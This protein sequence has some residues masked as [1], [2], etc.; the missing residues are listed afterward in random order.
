MKA[1]WIVIAA[2]AFVVTACGKPPEQKA[3]DKQWAAFHDVCEK[4]VAFAVL[5]HAQSQLG[6]LTS[7]QALEKCIADRTRD[8]KVMT[9]PVQGHVTPTTNN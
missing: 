5:I 9:T 8:Y 2:T 4:E 7:D 3:Q 6:G 1:T